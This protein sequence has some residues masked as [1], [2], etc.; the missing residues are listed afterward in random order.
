MKYKVALA[1]IVAVAVGFSVFCI[2]MYVTVCSKSINGNSRETSEEV[3]TTA[4]LLYEKIEKEMISEFGLRHNSK[5]EH[6]SFVAFDNYYLMTAKINDRVVDCY[7]YIDSNN[8]VQ[9]ADN[10]YY[11]DVKDKVCKYIKD[12]VKCSGSYLINTNFNVVFDSASYYWPDTVSDKSSVK[13]ILNSGMSVVIDIHLAIAGGTKY[14]IGK[15]KE[16]V[17]KLGLNGELTVA[18]YNT[19]EFNKITERDCYGYIESHKASALKYV[20]VTM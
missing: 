6:K 15:I 12:S 2:Y 10:Y 8:K 1:V 17:E 14:N 20:V 9:Y 16:S 19:K 18:V 4:N 11:F 5:V 13:E 3:V 7:R